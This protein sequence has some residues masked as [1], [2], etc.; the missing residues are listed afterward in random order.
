MASEGQKIYARDC[1]AC[2]DPRAEFTN[3]VVPITEIGTDPERMYS[4]SK[5]AAA[6]ANR[7][8]KQLGIDRPPMVETQDPY[9]Y[10]SPPLDGIWLRAPYLHN[11]S[12][13][14]LRDLLNSPGERPQ[15]FHRGYD[16][17]DPVKVG[18]KEPLPRPTGPTGELRQPYFLFDTTEKGN[19]NK[20]HT[21]GT[22]LSEQ[23]KE[24]LLEYLKTL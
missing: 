2:H 21:Y 4:W 17:F 13:P 19:G 11:G 22:Q 12:V 16:V 18:F 24:K 5:D 8:V 6:E 23:D 1:A 15:T 9:G 20:G 10:V 3:K 14:T 7:R